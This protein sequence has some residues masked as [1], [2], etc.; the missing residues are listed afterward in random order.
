VKDEVKEA[1][2]LANKDFLGAGTKLANVV[3]SVALTISKAPDLDGEKAPE[4]S[5][6]TNAMVKNLTIRAAELRARQVKKVN[7]SY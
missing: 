1:L 2:S 4:T 3:D 5:E 6:E 7:A